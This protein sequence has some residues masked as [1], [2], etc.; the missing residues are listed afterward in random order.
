M[1]NYLNTEI[2]ASNVLFYINSNPQTQTY[3]H[4][5]FL[6]P[7][8]KQIESRICLFGKRKYIF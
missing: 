4:K 7:F 1:E 8:F 3:T 6:F 2:T 5:I